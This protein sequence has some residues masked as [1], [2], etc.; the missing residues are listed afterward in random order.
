MERSGGSEPREQTVIRLRVGYRSVQSLVKEYTASLGRGGCLLVTRRPVALGALF[1]FEMTCDDIEDPLLVQG[2]VVR[3]RR[4]NAA[5]EAY[6]LAVRYRSSAETRAALEVMLAAIDVDTS[7][8]VVREAPRIPVNLSAADSVGRGRYTVRDVSRG[9]ARVECTL[10]SCEV[11]LGDRV[12]LGVHLT[13]GPKVFIGSTVRW[14]GRPGAGELQFGVKF[15]D[16]GGAEDL[17][18]RAVDN[19]LALEVPS[20]LLV[21]VVDLKSKQRRRFHGARE[22]RRVELAEVRAA[23]SDLLHQEP[24]AELGL[25][26]VDG[27]VDGL[28]EEISYVA[29]VGLRGDLNGELR[30]LANRSLCLVVARTILA[31]DDPPSDSAALGDALREFSVRLAGA[32]CDHLELAGFEVAATP[33]LLEGAARDSRWVWVHGTCL[34][35]ANGLANLR[36]ICEDPTRPLGG[37]AFE[38]VAPA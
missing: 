18:R 9:G 34:A 25:D 24:L 21:H 10:G 31:G 32:L 19:L 17:R 28:F 33:P 30:V 11:A 16:L 26:A 5:G 12:L 38:L 36:V 20:Q 7:Y 22:L 4:V 13:D 1:L 35:G 8:P 27:S 2:E 3:V 14:A 29:R 23:M 15:D 6:E 37:D